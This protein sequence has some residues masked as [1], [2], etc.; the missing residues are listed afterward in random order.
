MKHITRITLT[1]VS[2]IVLVAVAACGTLEATNDSQHV[3]ELA[4]KIADFDL[5]AGYAP[6][7][8]AEISGY[9]LAAY[10]GTAGPSH[11]FLIQS[12]HEADGAELERMLTKLAPGSSD[13]NT[14]MT[15]IK[16]STA[17]VR[18]QEVAVIVSEGLNHENVTYRQATVGFQ[19][20]GGPAMLVFSESLDLWDQETLDAFLQSIQ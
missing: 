8:S 14:R 18:G 13:P 10:K 19:G 4:S 5:P 3:A 20:K 17:T 1:V 9:T 6:E 15:V 16:N 11:L 2:A 7:F 12:E